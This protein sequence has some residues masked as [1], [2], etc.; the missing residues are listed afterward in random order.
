MKRHAVTL[1]CGPVG[2]PNHAPIPLLALYLKTSPARIV[3]PEAG[4]IRRGVYLAASPRALRDYVL[5]PHD[6]HL[7]G[8]P[9]AG[10]TE[11]QANRSWLVLERCPPLASDHGRADAIR[12]A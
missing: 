4:Q 5:D 6:P 3:S 7:A 12:R 10:F 9:P 8:G 11:V 1:A 2:V